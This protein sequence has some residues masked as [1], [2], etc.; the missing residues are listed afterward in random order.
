MIHL[1]LIAGILGLAAC[2]PTTRLS[3]PT[4]A[5][6]SDDGAR[7]YDVSGNGRVDFAVRAGSDGR[8]EVL[9]YR[10]A[11]PTEEATEEA[12]QAHS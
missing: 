4:E 2:T 11:S 10:P 8:A 9:E 6:N 7:H 3:F 1:L 12:R 5:I